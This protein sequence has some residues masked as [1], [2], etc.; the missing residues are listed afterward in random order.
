MQSS[1]TN[2]CEYKNTLTIDAPLY[3]KI[4]IRFG[5]IASISQFNVGQ[6][7]LV[8]VIFKGE[9]VLS[10]RTSWTD[11]NSFFVDDDDD[12]DVDDDVWRRRWRRRLT[13]TLDVDRVDTVVRPFHSNFAPPIN[14]IRLKNFC[15][16]FRWESS[17]DD[18]IDHKS[19]PHE[20]A[21]VIIWIG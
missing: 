21:F 4:L 8:L 7:Q 19:V 15:V 14:F 10:L 6:F 13:T 9:P 20:A 18:V 3:I 16:S 5:C 11:S 17:A 12:D 2:S 1:S